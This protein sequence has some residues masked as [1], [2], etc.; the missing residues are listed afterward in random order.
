MIKAPQSAYVSSVLFPRHP[1][2]TSPT[3][4]DHLTEARLGIAFLQPGISVKS[5]RRQACTART[6]GVDCFTS[7][8]GAT[9]E[10]INKMVVSRINLEAAAVDFGTV[11][12]GR[13]SGT[14]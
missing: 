8:Q 2:F 12:A 5:A 14:G 9:S 3:T 11:E 13:I 10:A 6:E 7:R 4:I 1:R